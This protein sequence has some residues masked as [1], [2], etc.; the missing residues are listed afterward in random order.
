MHACSVVLTLWDPMGCSPP[1][2]S[3]H[4]II[5]QEYWSRLPFPSSGDLPDTGIEPA[6][7]ISP[8]LA[9]IFFTIEPSGK[10]QTAMLLLGK[11]G[12]TLDLDSNSPN[13]TN[14]HHC[15]SEQVL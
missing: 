2:S 4:G 8:A 11:A 12:R 9:G 7:L 15:D 13:S 1:G 14:H 3:V 6:S 5:Q 10:P